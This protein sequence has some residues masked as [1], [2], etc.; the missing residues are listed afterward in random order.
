MI[1]EQRVKAFSTRDQKIKYTDGWLGILAS[2]A[3][4][5]SMVQLLGFVIEMQYNAEALSAMYQAR[6][7][8]YLMGTPF[9]ANAAQAASVAAGLIGAVFLLLRRKRAYHWF[10]IA[11]IM[12]LVSII[13]AFLRGGFVIM[14]VS[15]SGMALGAIVVN[16][17]I[18]WAAYSAHKDEQLPN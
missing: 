10:I 18:F 8:D 2:F 1:R 17:F 6:Q 9:W 7:V 4:A 3:V 13:D 11:T 14:G 15:A 5:W 12:L 16:I